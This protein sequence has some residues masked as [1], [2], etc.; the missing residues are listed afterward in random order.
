MNNTLPVAVICTPDNQANI[1][2]GAID[3]IIA[4]TIKPEQLIIVYDRSQTE[5]ITA[6]QGRIEKAMP[7]LQPICV[8]H[9]PNTTFIAARNSGLNCVG[10]SLYIHFVNSDIQLPKDFY[11]KAAQSLMERLDC[12]GV[13]P[14]R[15]KLINSPEEEI[16]SNDLIKNPWLWLMRAKLD[17]ASVILLRRSAVEQAGKFNPL[18]L[19]GAATDFFAR[20]SNQGAWCCIPDCVV[21]QSLALTEM[22]AQAQFPDYHRR[23]ALVYE[24][25]LDTYRARNRIPR[26]TY[27]SILA[28][29]WCE[30]GRELLSH[31]RIEEARDCFMRS[32]SWRLFNPSFKYL[33]KISRLRRKAHLSKTS[34]I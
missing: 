25:L 17:I 20:L 9:D 16:D 4:Q 13:V 19:V 23:W 32:L 21:S 18:L 22:D 5:V 27:K 10:D 3:S 28:K 30:A 24:N 33:M 26:P 14:A 29:A 7:N 2:C 8:E 11:E 15:V 31:R 1:P 34:G 6:L 12:V